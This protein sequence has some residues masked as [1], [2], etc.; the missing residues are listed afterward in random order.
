MTDKMEVLSKMVDKYVD[1]KNVN[2]D[3]VIVNEKG[4]VKKVLD[5]ETL[6]V[7]VPSVGEIEVSIWDVRQ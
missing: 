6:L 4:V 3:G 7:N 5:D 1:V 2:I